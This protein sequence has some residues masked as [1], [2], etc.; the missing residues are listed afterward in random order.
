MRGC[1]ESLSCVCFIVVRVSQKSD[2]AH[3]YS[4]PTGESVGS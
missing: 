3:F 4:A 2:I 1:F